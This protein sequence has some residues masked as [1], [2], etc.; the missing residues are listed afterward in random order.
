MPNKPNK[1]GLKYFNIV[2]VETSYLYD[3]IPYLGKSNENEK[4][5]T[6]C[7]QKIVE[8]LARQFYGSNRIIGCDNYFTNLPSAK[9]L[10]E[11]KLGII[12]TVRSNK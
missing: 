6:G 3:T 2:D 9:T 1:Y 8:T 10:F 11:N 12:G 4:N 7:G 5:S